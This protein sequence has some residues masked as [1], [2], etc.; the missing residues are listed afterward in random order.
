MKF[1]DSAQDATRPGP[2]DA[3]QPGTGDGD[4]DAE[5]ARSLWVQEPLQAIQD[6]IEKLAAVTRQ[7]RSP[8]PSPGPVPG[9]TR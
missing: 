4:G 9:P 8:R 6:I 5:R 3:T 2:D 7:L 1:G